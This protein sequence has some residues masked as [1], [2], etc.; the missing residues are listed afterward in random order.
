MPARTQ[1]PPFSLER[2]RYDLS[3]YAGRV[4]NMVDMIDPRTL[5]ASDARVRQA[6]DTLDRVRRGEATGLSDAELW[7][8]RKL[9]ESAVHP[10]TGDIVPRPFRMAGYV[11]YGTPIVI[12]LVVPTQSLVLTGLFQWINCSHN[13]AVNYSN[14]NKSQAAPTAT[15]VQG[16]AATVATAVGLSVGL[17]MLTQRLPPT[18]TTKALSALLPFMAVGSANVT[19]VAMMRRAELQSGIKVFTEE[20]REL[21]VSKV[22]AK[23]AITMTAVTRVLLPMPCIAFPPVIMTLLEERTRLFKRFPRARLP[24]LAGI[25]TALFGLGLALAVPLFPQKGSLPARR[26]ERGLQDALGDVDLDR[27]TI[28]YNKGL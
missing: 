16:Y 27:T 6:A 1:T 18:R 26:L 11:P 22:A 15:L 20:G 5:L 21:G 2:N 19:N 28:V 24:T 17:R 4:A 23:D 12:A 10:D 13:A 8:E 25:T 9:K 3:T 7:A 14:S